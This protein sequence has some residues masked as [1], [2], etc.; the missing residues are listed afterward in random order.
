MSYASFS[1]DEFLFYMYWEN[2][3]EMTE[4]V[5]LEQTATESTVQNRSVEAVECKMAHHSLDYHLHKVC[6][7]KH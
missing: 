2:S 4:W 7:H 1:L 5:K 6:K 3:R